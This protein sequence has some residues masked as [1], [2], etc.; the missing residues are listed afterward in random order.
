MNLQERI[1]H[2]NTLTGRLPCYR[3]HP[4]VCIVKTGL[5]HDIQ[6]AAYSYLR[7]T[8]SFDG[9][10]ITSQ[11]DGLLA[12]IHQFVL[13]SST[14]FKAITP[15]GMVV[16]KQE[17]ILEF[18]VLAKSFYS[19]ICDL[20]ID[21]LLHSWNIPLNLRLKTGILRQGHLEK[22]NASEHIH[23]DA[24]AGEKPNCGT[25]MLIIAGDTLFNGIEFYVPPDDFSEDWLKTSDAG[26]V[27][28]GDIISKYKKL[29]LK[30]EVG[31]LVLSDFSTLHNSQKP[32]PLSKPRLSIDSVF[33]Y[34]CPENKE[35]KDWRGEHADPRDLVKIGRQ[36]IFHT[37]ASV[38]DQVD[39]KGGFKQATAVKL[40]GLTDGLF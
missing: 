26:Y 27:D 36:L 29:P 39:S 23:S 1:S 12:E 2:F 17:S 5:K 21:D 18:N 28:K 6:F 14:T 22:K 33:A 25:A 37:N 38:E 4:L 32:T 7:R 9:W 8:L 15:N 20:N 3:P 16:P 24:W 35:V 11:L 40:Y 10:N 30:L 34:N 31:D 13:H 19:I